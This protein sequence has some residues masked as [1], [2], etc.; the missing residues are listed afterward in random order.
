MVMI[1]IVKV[2]LVIASILTLGILP[3][4]SWLNMWIWN[5][6]IVGH[7]LSCAVPITSFWIIMGLTLSGGL[8][9]GGLLL[10]LFSK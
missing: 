7:V 10:K 3:L 6:V 8:G 5:T 2:I 9:V 4:V 1:I